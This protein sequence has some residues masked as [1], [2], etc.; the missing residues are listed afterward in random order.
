MSSAALDGKR[1]DPSIVDLWTLKRGVLLYFLDEF[2]PKRAFPPHVK[3]GIREACHSFATF[4]A[5]MGYRND[6]SPPDQSWRVQWPRSGDIMLQLIEDQVSE[7]LR[8]I[9]GPSATP[10]AQTNHFRSCMHEHM[11]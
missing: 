10:L 11:T 5:K 7:D 8:G 1:T 3:A 6:L 4:R 9:L 2:V